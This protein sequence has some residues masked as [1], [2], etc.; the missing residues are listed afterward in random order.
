MKKPKISVLITVYNG[1]KYLAETL[2]SV[3]NQTFKNFELIL[4]NDGSTDNTEGI[5][6]EYLKK[7]NR[8]V[9]LKLNENRGYENLHNVINK[10]LAIAKGKYIARLDA[11][12]I[13]YPKRLEVQYGYLEKHP[14]IFILGSSADVIDGKGKK[15]GKLI[16][17]SWP[18]IVL[19]YITG[20]NNPFIHSSVM[21]RNEGRKYPSNAEHYFFVQLNVAGKKL[22]N[23]REKLVKY[24]I[25]PNG[26]VAKNSDLRTNKY[27]RFYEK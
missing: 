24:R 17:K 25:N 14:K 3:L 26:L 5:I 8:V 4:V 1:E 6:K 12:D 10:G 13:C 2:D 27:R 15:I 22:H 18:P 9:Y 23:L 16:K 20:F 19:K 21:F 11:D 7:D